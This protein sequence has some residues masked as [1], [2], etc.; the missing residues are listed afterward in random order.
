MNKQIE[1]IKDCIDSVYGADCAYYGVDGIAIATVLHQQGYRKAS[2]VAREIFAEIEKLLTLLDKRHMQAGNPKQSWGIRN[3]MSIGFWIGLIEQQKF[4]CNERATRLP[5][6]HKYVRQV[7]NE[8]YDK[9]CVNAN[10]QIEYDNCGL[11][12]LKNRLKSHGV[13]FSEDMG[14]DD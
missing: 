7:L 14:G 2:E 4:G 6:L 5:A 10:G 8:A 12:R 3:A 1:E 9:D 11:I 13:K